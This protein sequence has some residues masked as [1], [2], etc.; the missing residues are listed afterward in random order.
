MVSLELKIPPVA[1]FLFCAL[2]MWLLKSLLMVPSL[3]VPGSRPIA[4]LVAGTGLTIAISGVVAFRAAKTTVDPRYPEKSSA[5]VTQGIFRRS[6]NPMYLG[7]L[8]ILLGWAVF[9][10][11]LLP[12]AVLPVFVLYMNYFQIF[13]EERAMQAS[14][15]DAYS[16]YQ[17]Q[18]G[19]WF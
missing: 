16:A 17:E 11:H 10:R 9:L 3:I 2:G 14:F 12:Y 4:M 6:R 7:L 15:G 1:V 19:R 13:P 18:V 5:I 8:L